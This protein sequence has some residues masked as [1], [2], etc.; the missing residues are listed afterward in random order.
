MAMH[1]LLK[2]AFE[3]AEVRYPFSAIVSLLPAP[4]VDQKLGAGVQPKTGAQ[5]V[6][7]LVEEYG[8]EVLGDDSYMLIFNTF[9]A[10]ITSAEILEK[11]ANDNRISGIREN[12]LARS[13][14]ISRETITA[15]STPPLG[16]EDGTAE[17]APADTSLAELSLWGVR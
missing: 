16:V 15:K 8:L 4:P 7:G 14:P 10:W 11:V 12:V 9:S 5:I 13:K 6:Q 17:P 1:S 3:N 2:K